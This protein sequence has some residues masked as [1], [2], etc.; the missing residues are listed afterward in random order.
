MTATQLAQELN[1]STQTVYHHLQKLKSAEMVEVVREERVG[2]LIESYYQASA[3]SFGF[4]M[5]ESRPSLEFQKRFV[6]TIVDAL[7][8]LG[9]DLE[10]NDNISQEIFSN[11]KRVSD[12][13]HSNSTKLSEI[14]SKLDDVDLE[15]KTKVVDVAEYLKLSDKVYDELCA[16]NRRIRKLYLSMAKAKKTD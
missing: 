13:L 6:K 3:E 1:L 10:Y 14:V 9:F 15:L 16:A 4:T 2:H 8:K 5:G 7:N 12:L 11:E